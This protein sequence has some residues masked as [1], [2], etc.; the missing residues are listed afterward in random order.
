[1][2]ARNIFQTAG[3][4]WLAVTQEGVIDTSSGTEILI[5]S[6]EMDE[7]LEWLMKERAR[8]KPTTGGGR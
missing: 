2:P 7:F 8:T 5:R 1:M 6:D 4:R 3:G